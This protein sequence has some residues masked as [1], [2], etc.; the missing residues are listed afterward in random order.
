MK[1][2]LAY[3]NIVMPY[4]P[5]REK[6]WKEITSYLKKYI[7]KNDIVLELGAGY[8]HFI[9]NVKAKDKYA[10]DLDKEVLKQYAA[11]GV[12]TISGDVLNI[13]KLINRKFD[14]IFASNLLEHISINELHS[15][16]P[17]IKE[18]LT[19]K[20]RFIILQPNYRYSFKEYFDDFDHITVF[21]HISLQRLLLIHGFK[22]TKVFKK[23]LPYSMDS[24][25]PTLK[26][27]VYL[28]LRIPIKLFAKQMLIIA[29]NDTENYGSR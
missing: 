2:S 20:G 21:D 12:H 14:I 13:K 11:T 7:S 1:T 18:M 27:L 16:F 10:L 15:L 5:R 26:W 24:K 6:V 17:I 28:Y 29:T 3:L 22:I 4:D 9:N 23:F 19:D 8:C 25:L